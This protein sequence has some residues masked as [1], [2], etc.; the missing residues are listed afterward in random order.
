LTSLSD[1]DLRWLD[2]AVRFASPYLGT[3]AD[4]PT[5]GAI[6]VN[7]V[8]QTVLGRAV[9]ARGGRPHAEAL[10]LEEAAG[11]AGGMT[12]YVTLEPC[13]HW[14]RT[15]PCVDAIIRSGILRVVIG[16]S[17]LDP[18]TAGAS[19]QRLNEAGIEAIV[20]DHLPSR[21][22][23]EGHAMRQRHGRPFVTLKMAVSSDGMIGRQ[24]EANVP[25]TGD[26]ARHWTHMQRAQADAVIIG[27]RTAMLDDPKLTVRLA[28]LERRT[29]LRVVL[30][31]RNGVDRKVN[32]VG[33]FTGHRVAIIAHSDIS[34]DAPAS[35]EVIKVE[36]EGQRPGLGL[37]LADLGAKGIQNVL[38]EAGQA[39]SDAF[40]NAGLVDRFELLRSDVV[41]GETGLAAVAHGTIEDRLSGAGLVA[42]ELQILGKD[43]LTS[44]ERIQSPSD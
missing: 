27:G 6:V 35:V 4:N 19:V 7:P 12:L 36:G 8:T 17:D 16:T 43:I 40:L 28:G 20:A 21:R 37:A 5:V 33:G 25:I 23:H 2:A 39:L 34:I 29:P 13:H 22:L 15:P 32:L 38:V 30:A 42:G 24:G 11:G 31:G 44:Y 14:G 26:M 18:R 41:I 1:Q 9:T 10:A 3:T